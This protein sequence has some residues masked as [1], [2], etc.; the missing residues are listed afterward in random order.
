MKDFSIEKF[1]K[2]VNGIKEHFNVPL[3]EEKSVFKTKKEYEEGIRNFEIII[4]Q[5]KDK[6][7]DYSDNLTSEADVCIGLSR[8]HLYYTGCDPYD[9][10][11][12]NTPEHLISN[13][14]KL[15]IRK[16]LLIK[17]SSHGKI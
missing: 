5:M 16:K 10:P 7:I 15:P 2:I 3:V 4:A 1:N 11:L 13:Y 14:K 6:P 8:S 17:M 12:I 9:T